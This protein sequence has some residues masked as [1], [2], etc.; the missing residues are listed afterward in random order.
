M[1]LRDRSEGTQHHRY[2]GVGNELVTGLK[3]GNFG[4]TA[5]GI[6][7]SIKHTSILFGTLANEW[8]E[9]TNSK[10]EPL[11]SWIEMA[12]SNN[13]RMKVHSGSS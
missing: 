7:E 3:D 6:L 5:I 1:M 8:S 13:A 2:G 9:S 11:L 12:R 10:M 4:N